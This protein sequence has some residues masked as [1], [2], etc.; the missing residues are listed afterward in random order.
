MV[1]PGVS[2]AKVLNTPPSKMRAGFVNYSSEEMVK[3]I[4]LFISPTPPAHF[5]S[6]FHSGIE[7]NRN[8]EWERVFWK[9]SRC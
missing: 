9:K 3:F 7:S 5:D 8:D 6:L 1:C 4:F 2:S